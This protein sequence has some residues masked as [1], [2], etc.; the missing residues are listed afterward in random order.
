MHPRSQLSEIDKVLSTL[1]E[2]LGLKREDR[3]IVRLVSLIIL[4][5]RKPP[6]GSTQE[7]LIYSCRGRKSGWM[8]H[9]REAQKNLLH[10]CKRYS[11]PDRHQSIPLELICLVPHQDRWA[12]LIRGPDHSLQGPLD[13]PRQ[14]DAPSHREC[15][16]SE[17]PEPAIR[18]E[19]GCGNLVQHYSVP[20]RENMA[21]SRLPV[22]VTRGTD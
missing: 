12:P 6:S 11:T 8:L 1:L 19:L 18:N 5:D 7:R 9:S 15:C 21:T 2:H 10:E 3:N 22:N 17:T 14:A 20:Y 16:N 13:A 4:V